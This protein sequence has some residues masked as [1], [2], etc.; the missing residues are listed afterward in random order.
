MKEQLANGASWRQ[1]IIQI[2]I[3]FIRFIF[4]RLE[5]TGPD[6]VGNLTDQLELVHHAVPVDRVALAVRGETTL[7][8]NTNLVESLLDG[9][10]VALGN[11]LGSVDDA[12][13][14]LFLVFHGGE[15]GGD[16]AQDDVLVGG[17]VLEGLEAAG[18]LGVVL[19]VVGVHVQL[20]EQLDGDAVVTTLG[21]VTAADEVTAA[22]VDTNVHVLGETD[23]G[24]V[25]QLDVLL[26]HVVGGVD[27]QRVLLEAS[28]E[29]LRAEVCL[30]VS[31]A[32]L[33]ANWN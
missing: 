7:G 3:R 26:E 16:N 4:A 11:D 9:D 22:Q 17:E 6:I 20:L 19:Q 28:K 30:Y 27:V 21:E 31:N 14:H 15:L 25:V 29:L 5:L 33:S 2:G 10:V 8:A 12:G 32:V 23:E 13:L 1:K 24:V 18:A